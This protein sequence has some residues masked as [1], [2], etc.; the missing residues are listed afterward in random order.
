MGQARNRVGR[1]VDVR[2]AAYYD[3]LSGHRRS[4][5]TFPTLKSPCVVEMPLGDDE[6][7]TERV[8][9]ERARPDPQAR[10]RTGQIGDDHAA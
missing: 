6:L 9:A 8:L 7:L 2:Y 3:N 5:G 4:A 10:P 1:H